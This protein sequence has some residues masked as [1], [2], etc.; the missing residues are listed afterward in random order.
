M[1]VPV[2]LLPYHLG[3]SLVLSRPSIPWMLSPGNAVPPSHRYIKLR[4]TAAPSPSNGIE[5]KP[6]TPRSAFRRLHYRLRRRLRALQRQHPSTAASIANLLDLIIERIRPCFCRPRI[7][8]PLEVRHHPPAL[9]F[10]HGTP[11]IKS[12]Q[13]KSAALSGRPARSASLPVP[14]CPVSPTVRHAC[15]RRSYDPSLWPAQ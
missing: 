12:L 3:P 5:M 13:G 15:H 8:H 6:H 2:Q 4:H 1:A 14:P 10:S 9:A 11:T 7:K